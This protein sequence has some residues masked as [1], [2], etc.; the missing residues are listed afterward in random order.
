MNDVSIRDV[1]LDPEWL[2]HAYDAD[3]QA[4]TFVHVPRDARSELTFLFDEHFAGKFTK[5]SFPGAS[6]EAALAAELDSAAQAPIHF[7]F[8]TSFS[9]SS[10]LA[11]ALEIPGAATSMREPAIFTNL[12][13]R[14]IQRDA[15]AGANRLEL[16]LRLLERPFA[17][18]E[19]VIVKQ[20]S[21]ANRLVDPVLRARNSS[22][23]VLLYSDLETYLI[24]LLKRGL[25]GRIWGRKLFT[26][27][28]GWSTLKFDL[29]PDETLEL[30]DMQVASLAWL[31]QIHQF[32][33]LAKAFG[34]R[35]ML[36]ESNEMFAAPAVTLHRVMTFFELGLSQQDAADIAAGPIFAKHS[37]FSD[38]DYDVEERRRDL[39]TI[40]NANSEELSMVAK[41]LTSFASHHGVSLRPTA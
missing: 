8:H 1:V 28:T 27:L 13:N 34:P 26:N 30:T 16:V 2:P 20:S 10:L 24:S 40:G 23:T 32:N 29:G 31:M 37:K 39:E 41:W 35:V 25:K 33:A 12:A 36:L 3:G 21:F 22:R 5:M 18:N 17:P 6:V 15:Q 14:V 19:A 4:L 11:R 7:I 38:R 9:G